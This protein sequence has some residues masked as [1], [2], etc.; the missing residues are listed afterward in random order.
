MGAKSYKS[1]WEW[2]THCYSSLQDSVQ[3][4]PFQENFLYTIKY[5]DKQRKFWS[6]IS[7]LP[8][9]YLC[10]HQPSCHL[11]KK[12]FIIYVTNISSQLIPYIHVNIYDV[13]IHAYSC[14]YFF[15]QVAC[16]ILVPWPGLN[17]F[18]LHWQHR[19]LTAGPPGSLCDAISGWFICDPFEY[20]GVFFFVLNVIDF[21]FK[22]L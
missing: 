6:L 14:C 4:L 13:Y 8:D 20:G 19:V 22:S 16:V 10:T 1:T 12:F 18:P 7:Q 9:F 15:G 11:L 5:L 17:L 3:V 21:Y 2:S